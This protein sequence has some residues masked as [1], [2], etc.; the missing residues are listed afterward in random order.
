MEV[1]TGDYFP[2][3]IVIP[4]DWTTAAFTGEVR[5]AQS[6]TAP[7]IGSFTMVSVIDDGASTT[8]TMA[9]TPTVTR[10]MGAHEVCNWDF[11]V[12]REAG[13]PMTYRRGRFVMVQD[14]TA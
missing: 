11:Q 3:T 2:L 10:A 6:V 12:E 9:L 7:L 14:V 1:V 4:G 5:S 8:V 13:Q